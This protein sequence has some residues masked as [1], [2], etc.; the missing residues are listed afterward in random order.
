[1]KPF[2]FHVKQIEAAMAAALV[3]ASGGA[4]GYAPDSRPYGGELDDEE[5]EGESRPALSQLVGSLP[6]FFAAYAGG[7]DEEA[8]DHPWMFGGPRE[9]VHRCTFTVLCC[10][11]DARGERA[12]QTEATQGVGVYDMIGVAQRALF[13]RQ[14]E[15]VEEGEKIILNDDPFTPIRRGDNVRFVV[16]RNDLVVFAV[17]FFTSFTYVTTDWRAPAVSIDQFNL[18]VDS[19]NTQGA[20]GGLPGV[21]YGNDNDGGG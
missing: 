7:A 6:I 11:S 19:R 2:E 21:H 13:G 18:T 16:R 8:S 17:H 4:E 12:G 15:V 20:A 14:F 5:I 9:M 10:A 3:V 1:M